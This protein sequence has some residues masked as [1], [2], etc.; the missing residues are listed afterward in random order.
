MFILSK[1]FSPIDYENIKYHFVCCPYGYDDNRNVPFAPD[2]LEDN[3]KFICLFLYKSDKFPKE[4][5]FQ[6]I[7]L[8]FALIDNKQ[9][10][11]VSFDGKYFLL[12]IVYIKGIGTN[13][14]FIKRNGLLANAEEKLSF[15]TSKLIV[16]VEPMVKTLIQSKT[17][18]C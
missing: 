7:N 6:T 11:F 2:Q 4:F 8:E 13:K 1:H 14:Y 18:L 10:K 16:Q 15:T 3:E 17:D 5:V 9:Q 12:G